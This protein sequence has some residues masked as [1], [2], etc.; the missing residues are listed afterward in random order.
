[1]GHDVA[2]NSQLSP[3]DHAQ[4]GGPAPLAGPGLSGG[5]PATGGLAPSARAVAPIMSHF[6]DGAPVQREENSDAVQMKGPGAKAPSE[7]QVHEAAARGTSGSGG[8]L[9][10]LDQIQRS[11]GPD[12]DVRGIKAHTG[13][14]PSEAARDMNAKGFT[15]GQNVAF[16]GTP[17]LHTAAHEAAHAVQQQAGVQLKGGVGQTGDQ[18]E[19]HADAV[20][21]RVV[22]GQPAGDLLSA[23]GP[24]GA[25]K[26]AGQAGGGPVQ[27]LG[28]NLDEP[29]PEGAE[30]PAHG[31]E[32]GQRRYSVEQYIDMW[33]KEQGRKLT[34][35][36][37]K[38]IDR[39]CIGITANNLSG[40]GNP[41]LDNAYSTFEAAHDA[42][43]RMNESLDA[44]RAKP[45]TAAQA[46]GKHAVVFAKMFWSNQ[47]PDPEKRKKP[48]DKAFRPD[49][50]GKVDM[51]GYEYR[52]QPGY[53][54]FDYAFWDEASQSFWHAN[55][56]Q[57]GMKVYQSTKDRFARGYID[58]DRVIYCVAI[59]ENYDPGLAAMA[60]AGRR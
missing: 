31:A 26:G 6:A 14:G 60:H 17:S 18:Y 3:F 13:S 28:Y 30:A 41:P 44:L 54:N 36:E 8:P 46:Q 27:R 16:D 21:D 4:E 40:G 23:M 5:R 15:S 42:M 57:P 10:Y 19:R 49:E 25:E 1:M 11:F 9:P 52:A 12:Y 20:A 7:A 48:D 39:G 29:L 43:G 2:K 35:R 37:K 22:A 24:K 58:F 47:D 32:R 45:E 59:A 34:D 53:I 51:S 38:T 50:H 33:E 56:S 55:H